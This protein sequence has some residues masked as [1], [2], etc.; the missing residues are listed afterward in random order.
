MSIRLVTHKGIQ[1]CL[2]NLLGL[3]LGNNH[4]LLIGPD[5]LDGEDP[6][7]GGKEPSLVDGIGNEYE[8]QNSDSGG[9]GAKDDE[10]ELPP[11]EGE[12]VTEVGLV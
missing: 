4:A 9:D 8:E 6:F 7:L 2:L 5:P 3:E 10:D 12:G 1:Q 11:G